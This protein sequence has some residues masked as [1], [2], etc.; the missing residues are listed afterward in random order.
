MGVDGVSCFSRRAKTAAGL[1]LLACLTWAPVSNGD[2]D[3][4]KG[5]SRCEQ[6]ALEKYAEALRLCELAQ[7]PDPRLRC[8]ESARA[9]YL[10][11]LQDCC[12]T[13]IT[14]AF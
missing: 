7:N 14:P 12:E 5:L 3:R 4:P 1:F 11:A 6:R 13:D 10:R 9:V 8:Y 2:G